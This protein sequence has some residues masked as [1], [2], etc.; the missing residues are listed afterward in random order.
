MKNSKSVKKLR[1]EFLDKNISRLV[2]TKWLLNLS[3]TLLRRRT[4]PE[5]CV[6]VITLDA[7]LEVM[8]NILI[9]FYNVKHPTKGFQRKLGESFYF[10]Q[11]IKKLSSVDKLK[12]NPSKIINYNEILRFHDLRN[13]IQHRFFIPAYTLLPDYYELIRITLKDTYEKILG[14]KWDSIS[15]G[16]LIENEEIR[17][18]CISGENYYSANKLKE[19]AICLI[20]A[21]EL[22][23]S[24]QKL[25]IAGSGISV[26]R[27]FGHS[28]G[29]KDVEHED[30][31]AYVEKIDEEIE[32]MKLGLNYKEFRR[33]FD[34]SKISALERFHLNALDRLDEETLN[35]IAKDKEFRLPESQNQ[36]LKDWVDFALD[37][38]IRSILQWENLPRIIALFRTE[39]LL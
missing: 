8:F 24:L 9:D 1:K 23:K 29:T 4:T 31:R 32:I 10:P 14:I 16:H 27:Y 11:I 17:K 30:L 25:D 21:F 3:R 37:F 35:Q 6:A 38:V 33:Y 5:I 13:Q 36:A 15:F 26:H 20:I 28:K 7:S 19:A 34:V 12:P 18:L 39:P 22:A 2:Y